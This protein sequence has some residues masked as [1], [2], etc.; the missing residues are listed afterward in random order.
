MEVRM[1][2]ATMYTTILGSDGVR[3]E[4]Y[5][6]SLVPDSKAQEMDVVNVY[7]R[8]RYQV[9]QGF[10]AALTESAGYTLARMSREKQK[11]IVESCYGRDG[12]GYTLGRIHM[13]SCDFSVSNYC[14]VKDPG[15]A[16]FGDFT[17][18][19]DT[20][21]VQ[22]LIKMAEEALTAGIAAAFPLVAAGFY[23]RDRRAQWWRTP[24]Q[25]MLSG[26][27]GLCGEVYHG[28]SETGHTNFLYDGAE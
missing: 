1:K 17:L 22:P 7:P 27:C 11:E 20:K 16:A 8:K 12:L 23:E 21:Y 26:L 10:G 15:D 25:G 19:R 28:V 14:A 13:D 2:K 3:Q 5:E 4:T 6:T 9:I 18:E 24:A